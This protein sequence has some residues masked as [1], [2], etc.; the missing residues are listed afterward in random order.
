MV[1]PRNA[2]ELPELSDEV[3]GMNLENV[4]ELK[5]GDADSDSLRTL[6]MWKSIAAENV[7]ERGGSPELPDG[8]RDGSL[9]EL[10]KTSLSAASD[11]E[12]KLQLLEYYVSKAVI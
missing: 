4:G 6:F 1:E 12:T 10:K 2:S 5:L 11:K 8:F 9:S 3:D 7:R